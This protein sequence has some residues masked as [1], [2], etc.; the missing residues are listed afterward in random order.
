MDNTN[1]KKHIAETAYNVGYSAKLHFSTFE[2]IEKLPGII[3]FI[4]MAFGIYALAFSQLS[5]K[6]MSCTLLILGL[7]GLYITMRNGNKSDYES[8]G[9]QLT[10][11][12]NE[13]KHLMSEAEAP[14]GND[15]DI[16]DKL[17]DIESRYSNS[18]ASDHIMFATW[19]AHYK[20]FWEQQTNWIQVYRPFKFFRDQVPLT[21][22]ATICVALVIAIFNYSALL[23]LIFEFAK[24][25]GYC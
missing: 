11:L 3:S 12:F 1:L 21:L 8:K 25:K 17:K 2:I 9:I 24:N 15:E 7:T 16:K 14:S 13:L 20:F 19:F 18:C 10:N 23:E 5:T 22:W 6:F 4:S